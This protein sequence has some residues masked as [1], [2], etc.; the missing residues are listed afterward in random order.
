M[1]SCEFIAADGRFEQNIYEFCLS[2]KK[3]EGDRNKNESK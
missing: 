2:D 1:L 3:S